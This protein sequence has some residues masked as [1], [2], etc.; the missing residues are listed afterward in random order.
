MAVPPLIQAESPLRPSVLSNKSIWFPD[1]TPAQ[2]YHGFDSG[3]IILWGLGGPALVLFLLIY[4]SIIYICV[5][6]R[7]EHY[8][9]RNEF[10]S[11]LRR[12]HFLEDGISSEAESN[13]SSQTVADTTPESGDSSKFA[14][15]EGFHGMPCIADSE[16]EMEDR[17]VE[18][19]SP[20]PAQKN[21]RSLMAL[22]GAV[23]SATASLPFEEQSIFQKRKK[24]HSPKKQKANDLFG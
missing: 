11:P 9:H 4:G 7:D 2:P 21:R 6:K 18:V 3:T 16:N 22:N 20:T 14:S 8:S 13:A 15:M 12:G 5:Y 23:A 17:K 1:D 19:Q 10:Q 24:K